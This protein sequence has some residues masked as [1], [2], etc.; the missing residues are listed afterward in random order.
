MSTSSNDSDFDNHDDDENRE[1]ESQNPN[2][3][4]NDQD[5]DPQTNDQTPE[6][7]STDENSSQPRI[8]PVGDEDLNDS[9]LGLPIGWRARDIPTGQQIFEATKRAYER[10]QKRLSDDQAIIKEAQLEADC[11]IIIQASDFAVLLPE[12]V[13]F[14]LQ[15]RGRFWAE[16]CFHIWNRL[17]MN[18]FFKATNYDTDKAIQDRMMS[19]IAFEMGKV[20]NVHSNHEAAVTRLKQAIDYSLNLANDKGWLQAHVEHFYAT[21]LQIP[22]EMILP[23]AGE[24]LAVAKKL[25]DHIAEMRIYMVLAHVYNLYGE[26]D[27][28]FTYGQQSLILAYAVNDANSKLMALSHISPLT[29]QYPHLKSYGHQIITLWQQEI[30]NNKSVRIHMLYLSQMSPYFYRQKQY[31]RA[32]ESYL[33]S[34]DLCQRMMDKDN[35]VRMVHGLG[36]TCIQLEKWDEAEKNLKQALKLYKELKQVA[37]QVWIQHCLGWLHIKRGNVKHGIKL[38]EIA[39]HDA[40]NLPLNIQR[41]ETLIAGI[42]KDLASARSLLSSVYT[43]SLNN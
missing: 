21:C 16:G 1:S 11:E 22:V 3:N 37:N 36:M 32:Y 10:V 20:S 9:F 27:K 18:L 13:G 28:G 14:A 17:L 25:Q 6:E 43:H 33:K 40:E 34:V 2:E 19:Q 30:R 38:L 39:L 42:K 12:V 5:D 7:D 4:N 24:L 31:N 26:Y 15:L 41:R 23:T 8:Q 35:L 29:F